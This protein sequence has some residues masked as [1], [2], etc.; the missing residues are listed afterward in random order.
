[1]KI[2]VDRDKC[3]ALGVCESL[4]PSRFEVNEDGDLDILIEDV[5]PQ[6]VARME[7]VVKACPTGALSLVD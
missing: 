7:E 4:E 5:D 6:D 1:M 3:T 2:C